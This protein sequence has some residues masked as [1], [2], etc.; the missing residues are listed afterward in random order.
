MLLL[1]CDADSGHRKRQADAVDATVPIADAGV[2][3]EDHACGHCDGGCSC[4]A[5]AGAHTNGAAIAD[6]CTPGAKSVPNAPDDPC[7]QNDPKCPATMYDAV[8]TCGMDG[9]WQKNA[10]GAIMCAC[11]PKNGGFCGNGLIDGNEQCDGPSLA[12]ARCATFGFI[13][14]TLLCTG[15]HYDVSSCFASNLRDDDGGT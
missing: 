12:G 2:H 1:A 15:C 4:E 8:T 3:D 11:V 13:D 6:M 9:T 7:P 14:G 5:D 10:G